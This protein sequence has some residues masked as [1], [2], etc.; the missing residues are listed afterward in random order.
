MLHK[1][2]KLYPPKIILITKSPTIVFSLWNGKQKDSK[3]NYIKTCA[4][5]STKHYYAIYSWK[6]PSSV[7][8]GE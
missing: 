8:W 1:I 4:T 7:V 6:G 3:A 2:K 5:F